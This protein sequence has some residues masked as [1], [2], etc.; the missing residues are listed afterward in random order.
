MALLTQVRPPRLRLRCP[1][2]AGRIMDSSPGI[3][4]RVFTAEASNELFADYLVKCR[5]CKKE[6]GIQK[7]PR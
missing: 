3:V 1:N 5:Q 7:V 4:S 2:C 6:I